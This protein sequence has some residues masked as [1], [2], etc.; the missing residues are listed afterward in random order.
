[1]RGLADSF[2]SDGLL[3]VV[4]DPIDNTKA[5]GGVGVL[6][7]FEVATGLPVASTGTH[8]YTAAALGAAG[9]RFFVLEAT[10]DTTLVSGFSFALTTQ[11]LRSPATATEIAVGVEVVT[12]D[13]T[14]AHTIYSFG[15]GSSLEGVWVAPL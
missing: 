4:L 9:S 2:S 7:S 11:D 15:A 1:V 6:R 13:A 12:V 3:A 8:V 10:P 14:R 5:A